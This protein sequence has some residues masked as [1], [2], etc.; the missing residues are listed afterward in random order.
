MAG[1]SWDGNLYIAMKSWWEGNCS[2]CVRWMTKTRLS[3]IQSRL[4][5]NHVATAVRQGFL[6]LTMYQ[7]KGYMHAD[8]FVARRI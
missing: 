7:L 1:N 6:L 3:H 5:S 2:P 8:S 4:S